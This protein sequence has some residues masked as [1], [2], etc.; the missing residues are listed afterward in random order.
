MLPDIQA[1]HGTSKTPRRADDSRSPG[2]VEIFEENIRARASNR[3]ATTKKFRSPPALEAWLDATLETQKL[4][5][6]AA[7]PERLKVHREALAWL[8]DLL[9]TYGHVLSRVLDEVDG[10]LHRLETWQGE[11]QKMHG[12][13]RTLQSQLRSLRVLHKLQVEEAWSV[14]KKSSEAETQPVAVPLADSQK[15][16]KDAQA[17]VTKRRHA[18]RKSLKLQS[19]LQSELEIKEADKVAAKDEMDRTDSSGTVPVRS[20]AVMPVV[21][22]LIEQREHISRKNDALQKECSQLQS[23]L[24]KFQQENDQLKQ[25]LNTKSE[26]CRQLQTTQIAVLLASQRPL[27]AAQVF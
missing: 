18:E 3:R 23:D 5:S 10:A 2:P 20:P 7:C 6:K 19:E 26:E 4:S 9:P 27:Q 21:C 24:R 25:Q 22:R 15:L 14:T 13:N 17:E 12:L 11:L 1:A 16:E 8:C